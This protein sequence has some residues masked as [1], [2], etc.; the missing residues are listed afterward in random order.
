LPEHG[1]TWNLIPGLSSQMSEHKILHECS[2]KIM[3]YS[4]WP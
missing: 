4:I 2:F 1:S 3:E